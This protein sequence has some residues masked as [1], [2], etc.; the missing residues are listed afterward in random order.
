M[1]RST[2]VL[3]ISHVYSCDFPFVNVNFE[4]KAR[5]PK[6]IASGRGVRE[7]SD[8]NRCLK[9]RVVRDLKWSVRDLRN[10]LKSGF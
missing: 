6:K 4:A 1:G 7:L 8:S 3:A 5:N 2:G 10:W 9:N